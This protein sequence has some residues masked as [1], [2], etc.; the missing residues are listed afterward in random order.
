LNQIGEI[1]VR[2]A[3]DEGTGIIA[4]VTPGASGNISIF[5]NPGGVF[6]DGYPLTIAVNDFVGIRWRFQG[7]DHQVEIQINGG[8]TITRNFRCEWGVQDG[9]VLFGSNGTNPSPRFLNAQL[10]AYLPLG[11]KDAVPL[12]SEAELM[13]VYNP[14]SQW[15]ATSGNGLNHP[16]SAG[17]ALFYAAGFGGVIAAV[18][19]AA[20]NP[21][22]ES[23]VFLT[24]IT[25]P[26]GIF[27]SNG[28]GDNLKI[29]DDAFIGD[30]NVANGIQIKGVANAAQGFI[31]FGSGSSLGYDGAKL[32]YGSN[33]IADRSSWLDGTFNIPSLNTGTTVTGT[34]SAPGASVSDHVS[35]VIS[36]I[37][38]QLLAF[39][40]VTSA[41]TLSY[42]VQNN[43]G[44]NY[45]AVGC[46]YR[47]HK[48]SW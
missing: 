31:K 27:T 45:A 35:L 42:T 30:A 21:P 44:S 46:Y 37:T 6:L 12:S 3:V 2:E 22:M 20:R 4:I 5:S 39:G 15:P 18:A 25:A 1:Y 11:T 8:A 19:D 41:G 17:H 28:A 48:R 40:Q 32:V 16:S 34:V 13:G 9:N 24:Q 7:A 26:K 33:A 10:Y 38:G 29:G 47:I 43:S 36:S 14:S 23:P